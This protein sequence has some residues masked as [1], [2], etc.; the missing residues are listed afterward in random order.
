M[1]VEFERQGYPDRLQGD[2]SDYID[3]VGVVGLYKCGAV[4]LKLLLL[5]LVYAAGGI[6][7][8]DS[9]S[10]PCFLAVVERNPRMLWAC[11]AVAF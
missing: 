2:A 6:R 1:L 11:H 3:Q 8:V 9:I 5:D 10:R 4:N 7:F